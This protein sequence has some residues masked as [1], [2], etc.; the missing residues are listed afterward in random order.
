MTRIQPLLAATWW[1]VMTGWVAAL[2]APGAAAM[3]AFTALPALGVEVPAYAA[4]F[5]DDPDG[6]ARLAAGFV[7][8]PIFLVADRM[9]L[10]FAGLAVLL[11]V[12][13]R[14]IPCGDRGFGQRLVSS[15]AL[16]SAL[17]CLTWYLLFVAPALAT[18]LDAWRA[19]ALADDAAAAS[20]AYQIFD[21]LHRAAER[22]M[23]AT[24]ASLLVLIVTCG[25]KTA[26]KSRNARR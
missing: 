11:V 16:L 21:P 20:T 22:L 8:Y 5:A 17:G 12:V 3:S 25:L 7:T 2:I 14:G 24:L 1:L 9:Q 19:A 10:V 18:S 23:T 15:L 26:T 6:A 4:F 13:G